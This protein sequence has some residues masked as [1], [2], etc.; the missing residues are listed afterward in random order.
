MTALVLDTDNT[1]S[2]T[3]MKVKG[4]VDSDS[5]PELDSALTKLLADG[6]NKIVL[7]FQHV[8]FMSSAGIRAVVKAAQAAAKSGGALR[9]A[10]VP[11][12][13]QS[14]LYT[15]GLNQMVDSYV[16]SDEA[17]ANF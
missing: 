10:A 14:V 11:E 3:V 1:K 6:R 4:R 2:V 12:A 17:L 9:L 8:E 13:V 7:N 5:A 15:V 16:S